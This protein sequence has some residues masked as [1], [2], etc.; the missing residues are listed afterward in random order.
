LLS[1]VSEPRS[2]YTVWVLTS[3]D[4]AGGTPELLQGRGGIFWQWIFRHLDGKVKHL[5]WDM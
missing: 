2:R 1:F 3:C 4:V 5:I